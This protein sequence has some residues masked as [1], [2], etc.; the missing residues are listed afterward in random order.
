MLRN[1][2]IN[3]CKNSHPTASNQCAS[4]T[5]VQDTPQEKKTV[6]QS[7]EAMK[8]DLQPYQEEAASQHLFI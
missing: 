7:K 3:M 6:H 4:N 2:V 5:T 1:L 8:V